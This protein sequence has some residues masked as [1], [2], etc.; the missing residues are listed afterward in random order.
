MEE[1]TNANITQLMELCS[2]WEARSE[3]K[4]EEYKIWLPEFLETVVSER[5]GYYALL[6][7]YLDSDEENDPANG[8]YRCLYPL[9][10]IPHGGVALVTR[11]VATLER[12]VE[13]FLAQM[14]AQMSQ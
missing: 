1:E 5:G 14:R 9:V 6:F 12:E 13:K 3:M 8:K 7:T 4:E 2:E 10:P 11:D